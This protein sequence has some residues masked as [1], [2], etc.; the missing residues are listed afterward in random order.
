MVRD[1]ISSGFIDRYGVL[2]IEFCRYKDSNSECSSLDITG[3]VEFMAWMHFC[4]TFEVWEEGDQMVSKVKT[5]WDG[6]LVQTG[7]I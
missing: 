4:T 1:A 7:K 3:K 6:E 5:Y 2:K